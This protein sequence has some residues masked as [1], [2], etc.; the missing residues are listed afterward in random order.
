MPDLSVPLGRPPRV[1]VTGAGGPSGVCFLRALAGSCELWAGD[2]DP[3]AAGLY[4]VEHARRWL[5]PRG[6][7]AAYAGRLQEL[8]ARLRI[9]VLVPTVDTELLPL[10][11]ASHEFTAAGTRVLVPRAAALAR[12]LDKW[13]LIE[14]CRGTVR[15]PCTVLLEPGVAESFEAGFPA[16]A[17]PRRGSGSRGVVLADT[18]ADLA[19]LPLDGSYLLQELLPGA[20]YSLDVL[21]ALDGTVRAAVPRV[22]DKTDSGIIVAGRVLHRPAL[23]DDA[24]K[25]AAVTGLH[26]I[27]NV[28]VR[29][30]REGRPAL[31]EV[32][33]RP[34]GGMS[35]TVAAGV[36]MPAWAVASLLGMDVPGHIPHR[37]LSVVRHWQDVVMDLGELGD[38]AGRA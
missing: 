6:D 20:E 10:A 14:A 17:K 28:Q 37:E 16:V 7:D 23:S 18:P 13:T 5:L 15:V 21:V 24:A 35:L 29:E 26:G 31:L 1:L 38:V 22:R 27:C 11:R 8:C 30:D 2:I 32:N 36:H 19:A 4:L 12:C 33:P 25:V 9:D 3:N 34:P